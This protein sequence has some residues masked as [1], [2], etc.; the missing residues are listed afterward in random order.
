[1]K[2]IEHGAL[3]HTGLVSVVIPP[4]NC[5]IACDVFPHACQVSFLT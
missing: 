4:S 5:F 3:L 2:R 1:L